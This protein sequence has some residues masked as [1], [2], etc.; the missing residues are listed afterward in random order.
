[1]QSFQ[2]PDFVDVVTHSYRHRFSLVDGDPQYATIQREL[3]EQPCISVPT[4]ILAGSNDGVTP[5]QDESQALRKFTGQ[6]HRSILQGVGHNVPQEA[7][8][9]FARAVLSLLRPGQP[10]TK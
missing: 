6:V 7:P 3:A 4:V 8:D 10:M 5:A 2:N 1:M 9:A